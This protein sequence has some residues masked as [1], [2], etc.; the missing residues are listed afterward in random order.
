MNENIL[1]LTLLKLNNW[2]PKKVFSFVSKWNFDFQMCL[3]GLSF[4]L[5]SKELIEFDKYA[6]ESE[7]EL[8]LN[9]SHNIGVITLFDKRFPKKLYSGTDKCVLLYYVGNVDLL[10]KPS[11]AVIGTRTPTNE[12]IDKGIIITKKLVSKG[13]VIVSG[14]A[15]GCD[16]VAHKACLDSN[17]L[18]IAVLPSSCD[19]P[20]PTS[21]KRLAEEII[22]N[23]GLLISEYGYGS[24]FSN[25]NYPQRDRI[26]SL[27]SDYIFVI[28]ASDDSGTMIAVKKGIKDNKKVY[29]IK[30]NNL[31]I[32]ND[33]IDLDFDI[34]CCFK[35]V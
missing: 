20:Q 26:Q 19:K 22:S 3:S 2:G 6:A 4:D 24:E 5:D 1:I 35:I 33:Y 7:I 13:F 25:F 29:A 18:T 30:G 27:L 28:Q 32:I 15:L 23:N 12:F 21:N 16:S 9:L 14:L 17:G 10:N 31:S 34:D 11:V 8:N